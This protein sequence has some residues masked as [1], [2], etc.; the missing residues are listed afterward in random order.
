MRRQ[1]GEGGVSNPIGGTGANPQRP[2]ILPNFNPDRKD[3]DG[4]K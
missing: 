1:D 4:L 2:L 3:L